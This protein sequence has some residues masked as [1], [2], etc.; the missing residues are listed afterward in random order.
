[1]KSRIINF[2][3]A[4]ISTFIK[5]QK[6]WSKTSTFTCFQ[7]DKYDTLLAD[8]LFGQ[9]PTANAGELIHFDA[10]RSANQPLM[11]DRLYTVLQ[12]PYIAQLNA[13]SEDYFE[14]PVS[15]YDKAR[16]LL[17]GKS[18]H[19]TILPLFFVSHISI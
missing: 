17:F 16:Y 12:A 11:N 10:Q 6:V 18:L 14:R 9:E 19:H 4:V 8:Q 7:N 13:L 2:A 5:K 3:S 15:L 1:M